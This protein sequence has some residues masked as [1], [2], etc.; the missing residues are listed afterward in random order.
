MGQASIPPERNRGRS[1]SPIAV[2]AVIG[3]VIAATLFTH[4]PA[5]SAQ[6]VMSDDDQYV[7]LNPLVR[8]PSAAAAGRFLR[9]VLEPSTV[10][11]YYQP[12]AMI[13]LM[14]DSA[15]GARPDDYRVYHRT[16]LALHAACTALIVLLVT[17]LFNNLAAAT[18]AG[19]L[20]G[21]HPG[22]VESIA[23][24]SDRKTV[25]ATFFALA[26]LACYV[27]H[28]RSRDERP[29]NQWFIA[30]IALFLLALM[31]KPTVTMLPI[32][33]CLLDLWP[34]DRWSRR[35]LLEKIPLLT[36]SGVFGIITIIS[37][38]RTADVVTP[39]SY[40]WWATPLLLFH[41]IVFYLWKIAWPVGLS[42]YY[43][44]PEPFNLSQGMV[45]IGVLGSVVV[46]VLLLLSL[47]RTRAWAVGFGFFLV[48][49]LPAM[50]L[51]GFTSSI[52][53][54]RFSYLPKVGLLLPIAWFITHH[55]KRGAARANA[56]IAIVA[57]IGVG[58]AVAARS[59]L[60]NWTTT[61]TMMR[62]MVGQAPTSAYLLSSFG[63]VLS[64]A[65]RYDEAAA[66]Y[67]RALEQEEDPIAHAGL[68]TPLAAAGKLDEAERHLKEAVR[69]SPR[70][71][72]AIENLAMVQD[73]LGKSDEAARNFDTALQLRPISASINYNYAMFHFRRG[74]LDEALSKFDAALVCDAHHAPSHYQRGCLLVSAG[75][76]REGLDA[77]RRAIQSD[78]TMLTA[79]NN[80][81]WLL[82]TADEASVRNG[83]EAVQ[84]AERAAVLT[85]YQDPSILET[86]AAAY[87]EASRIKDAVAAAEK[88][89]ARWRAIGQP[90]SA[91][92][93]DRRLG[94]YRAGRPTHEPINRESFKAP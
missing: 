31:S 73:R 25:L 39:V 92:V 44:W 76:T 83:A 7:H 77:W 88:S 53:A 10:G 42:A 43:P 22:A 79:M 34:L 13:S 58:E 20:F 6:A 18:A 5:L 37:Q 70:L 81:A 23:W 71:A 24:V 14:L 65:G 21:L 78:P 66:Y 80:L 15:M 40:P 82:A 35:S 1:A 41:N 87:A 51:V 19:L 89:A 63:N 86:L 93:V 32:A 26:S 68:A 36:L 16:S 47:R 94:D 57:V 27:N 64:G 56:L 33:L 72:G 50:G 3:V 60:S 90:A 49:I 8:N 62:Y 59:Y 12:L 91:A 69:L 85:N 2:A 30:C 45:Q 55:W 4:W 29:I 9:E 11:G 46:G 54:D 67:R 61:E 48:V 17:L 28:A 84:I 38:G 52:A 75:R 74:R